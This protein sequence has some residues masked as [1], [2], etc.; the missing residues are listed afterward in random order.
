MRK[1]TAVFSDVG[2]VLATN[3]WDRTSRQQAA[4]KFDISWAEFEER[5]ELLAD[6]FE[7]GQL[8]LDDYLSRTVF[9]RP[10]SFSQE[11]FRTFMFAQSQ[12]FPESLEHFRRLASSRQYFMATLN[13][14]SLDLNLYRIQH[15]DLKGIFSVFFSSCFLGV[16]KPDMAIYET[17]LKLTSRE[18][19]ECLFIDDRLLN[20]EVAGCCGMQT[21][22]CKDPRQLPAQMRD[23]GLTDS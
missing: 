8:S 14:E 4:A 13:N 3:G 16:K 19:Q 5:H 15:L 17:A 10:R 23:L 20:V 11:Q 6:A 12:P 22:H 21:L 7:L 2:G 9:F 1:I 18:P